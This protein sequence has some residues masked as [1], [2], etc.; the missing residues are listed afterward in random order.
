MIPR[1][2]PNGTELIS[3]L[4]VKH[5]KVNLPK[6]RSTLKR[7]RAGRSTVV[8]SGRRGSRAGDAAQCGCGL[9]ASLVPLVP[10][11]CGGE[12]RSECAAKPSRLGDGQLAPN[13]RGGGCLT[14]KALLQ[15][16]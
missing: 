3:V 10:L 9:L 15:P 11:L 6:E 7:E 1:D 5:V 2:V 12:R 14:L 8:R 16:Y 4:A 13:G